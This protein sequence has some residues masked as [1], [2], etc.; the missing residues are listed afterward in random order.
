[1]GLWKWNYHIVNLF[2]SLQFLQTKKKTLKTIHA[3]LTQPKNINK[4]L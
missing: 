3:I 4:M 2:F 1:M